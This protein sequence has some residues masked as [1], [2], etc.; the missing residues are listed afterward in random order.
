[1]FAF[2]AD[3]RDKSLPPVDIFPVIFCLHLSV[4]GF[5][6]LGTPPS[7]LPTVSNNER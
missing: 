1:M 7:T 3:K 2:E 6:E 4:H 5:G